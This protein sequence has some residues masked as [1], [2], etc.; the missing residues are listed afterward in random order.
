[1]FDKMSR[2]DRMI[3]A[4]ATQE[5]AD[6]GHRSVGNDH[7]I[8]GMLCNARSPI[9]GLLAAQ[10]LTLDTARTSVRE[11][12]DGADGEPSAERDAERDAAA[13]DDDAAG[14]YAEDR[15]ALK[16]IGIDLDR[17]RE[18]VRDRFGEDLETG[19]GE[20]RGRGERGRGGR[21]HRHGGHR[22]G[23]RRCDDGHD[24]R[25]GG[26]WGDPRFGGPEAGGP[27]G[28]WPGWGGGPGGDG[29]WAFGRGRRGPRGGGGRPRFTPEAREAISLAVKN[30][31]RRGERR[32]S[33]ELVLLGILETG[34]PAS[35]ALIESATT[36]DDLRAAVAAI[37]PEPA[38][39]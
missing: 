20:R 9:F 34:D 16:S 24:E 5:A 10:G 3:F 37:L 12:H 17:V 29:P 25:F 13:R 31:R 32:L 2:D 21:G 38:Q 33:P 36:V 28:P 30:V 35:V 27:A 6:L 11:Y 1:M 14:R 15:A 23:G 19:W 8:L 7:V 39:T 4:F 18:A 22:Q 26:P